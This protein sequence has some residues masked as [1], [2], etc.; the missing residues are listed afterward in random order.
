MLS[1][2]AARRVQRLR[3]RRVPAAV[4]G[5]LLFL[6]GGGY[7]VWASERLQSTP[8]AGEIDAFDAPIARLARVATAEADRLDR[9]PPQTEREQRLVNELRTQLDI[10]G[11]LLI[12]LLRFLVASV[13][14]VVGL[15]ILAATFAQWPLLDVIARMERQGTRR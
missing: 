9:V 5:A 11:R 2:A 15:V 8:A 14:M 12:A 10:K 13:L 3:S 1:E 6:A 7:G 4:A